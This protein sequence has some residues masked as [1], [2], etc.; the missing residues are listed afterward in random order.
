MEQVPISV[1]L[2]II[3]TEHVVDAAPLEEACASTRVSVGVNR[4]GDFCGVYQA[5]S[6]A[7][8]ATRVPELMA[9]ALSAASALFQGLEVAAKQS[10]ERAGEHPDLPPMAAG[11]FA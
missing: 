10:A 6:S 8:P 7:L 4:R 1:T 5:G 9:C 2:S 11:F 3:G